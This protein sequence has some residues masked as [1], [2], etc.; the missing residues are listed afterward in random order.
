MEDATN[1]QVTPVPVN[2]ITAENENMVIIVRFKNADFA[3]ALGE[4]IARRGIIPIEG[5]YRVETE[6][7][8]EILNK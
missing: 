3:Q 2:V 4:E 7:M 1:E 6:L 8:H 5:E